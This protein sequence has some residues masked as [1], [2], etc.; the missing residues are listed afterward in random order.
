MRSGAERDPLPSWNDGAAK[1][2][3]VAFVTAATTEGGAAYVARGP[4]RSPDIGGPGSGAEGDRRA[5]G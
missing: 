1:H 2:A 5:E 3:L 4:R